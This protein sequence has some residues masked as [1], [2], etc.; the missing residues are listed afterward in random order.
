M[1]NEMLKSCTVYEEKGNHYMRLVYEYET[2]EGIF[3]RT[4][5]KVEFPKSL[6]RLPYIQSAISCVYPY[7]SYISLEDDICVLEGECFIGDKKYSKLRYIDELI[8]PK[9]HEMTLEEIEKKLGYSV[10]IVSK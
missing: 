6:Y 3:R 1:K 4:Y 5:P 8:K 10:K 7:R 9:V 2:E